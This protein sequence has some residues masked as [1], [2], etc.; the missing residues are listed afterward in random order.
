MLWKVG[1]ARKKEEKI[2]LLGFHI[3]MARLY[4][5]LLMEILILTSVLFYIRI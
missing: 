2:I 1:T 4:A 3:N 5:R